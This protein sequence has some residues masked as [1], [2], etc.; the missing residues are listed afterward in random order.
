[1]TT[2][3][4]TDLSIAPSSVPKITVSSTAAL[5][6]QPPA[7]PTGRWAVSWLALQVSDYIVVNGQPQGFAPMAGVVR[8]AS[9]VT[10]VAVKPPQTPAQASTNAQYRFIVNG[11]SPLL[12][13]GATSD[14]PLY[15]TGSPSY[16]T[17]YYLTWYNET[18]ITATAAEMIAGSSFVAQGSALG[19][20]YMSSALFALVATFAPSAANSYQIAAGG[21]GPGYAPVLNPN[22]GTQ[23]TSSKGWAL[24]HRH[25]VFALVDVGSGRD[26]VSTPELVGTYP[27]VVLVAFATS[28]GQLIVLGPGVRYAVPFGLAVYPEQ[29]LAGLTIGGDT[30]NEFDLLEMDVS[31]AD[32]DYPTLDTLVNNLDAAWNVH[33]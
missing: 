26:I 4:P 14:G 31:V 7:P 10:N 32:W 12:P 11:S 30:N 27:T 21:S 19:A 22:M 2:P 15:F 29:V 23:L 28:G 8:M 33:G 18:S 9:Q 25:G 1:M 24:Q 13:V 16:D 20:E 17:S 3:P 6:L 5:S